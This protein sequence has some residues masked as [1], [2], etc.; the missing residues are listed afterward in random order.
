MNDVSPAIKKVAREWG[1]WLLVRE[2]EILDFGFLGGR[3]SATDARTDG[4]CAVGESCRSHLLTDGLNLQT[5][6]AAK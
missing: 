2:C 3:F 4:C 6:K 5:D 1:V